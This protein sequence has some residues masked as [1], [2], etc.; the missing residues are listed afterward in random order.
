[1]TP[2]HFALTLGLC[3]QGACAIATE[4]P[5]FTVSLSEGDFEVRDYPALIVA[6]VSVAGE[7]KA[8]ASAGFRLL[9]GYIF[10][11]NTAQ[12][13]IAMT[14][15]VIQA[16]SGEKIA[17]TAPVLQSGADGKWVIRFIMPKGSS[18][19]TLPRPNNP[20][21]Q[22]KTTPPAR[23]AVVHFS[24][25]AR[26]DRIA[27]KTA[28]LQGF[29]TAQQLHAIGTPVLAQYDPPWTL[30]FLRRNELMIPIAAGGAN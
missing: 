8:A 26:Q 28:A 21:V 25:L 17:M 10:G 5:A 3:L 2:R 12:Q 23:M 29:V 24:G 9:A 15:P 19:A 14:A 13:N 20:M 22:L 16:A 6:E 11:G 1:M 27:A 30:W 7:R 4:E 18:L